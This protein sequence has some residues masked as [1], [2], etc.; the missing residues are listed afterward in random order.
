MGGWGWGGMGRM[1]G[2]GSGFRVYGFM[3]LGCW[4]LV[5][6]QNTCPSDG[7]DVGSLFG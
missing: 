3:G 7:H 5:V 2:L 6:I 1:I 4:D